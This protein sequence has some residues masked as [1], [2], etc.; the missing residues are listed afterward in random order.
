MINLVCFA[1]N[2]KKLETSMDMEIHQN[3]QFSQSYKIHF[4][5]CVVI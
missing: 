5:Y 3:C 2:F 1:F 4:L